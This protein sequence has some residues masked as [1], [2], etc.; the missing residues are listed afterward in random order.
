M[1]DTTDRVYMRSRHPGAFAFPD[2]R[3]DTQYLNV[4]NYND[5]FSEHDDDDDPP[6]RKRFYAR[7]IRP[8]SGDVS[9][10]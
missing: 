1:V 10:R 7:L 2:N 9:S 5:Y 6:I 3:N 8:I 4:P